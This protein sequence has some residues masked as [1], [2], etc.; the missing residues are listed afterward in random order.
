ML[1]GKEMSN[2]LLSSKHSQ[3]LPAGRQAG[4]DGRWI[5]LLWW[6]NPPNSPSSWAGLCLGSLL[7]KKKERTNTAVHGIALN[8]S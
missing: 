4:V 7:W 5:F 6:E 1:Q 3:L 8:S 2:P